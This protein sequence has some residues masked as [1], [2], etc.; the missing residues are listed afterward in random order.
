MSPRI[1][2]FIGTTAELIK[3]MPV[4]RELAARG[5][6]FDVIASG[7]NDLSKSELFEQA[8]L[9]RPVLALNRTLK[10]KTAFGLAI[11]F[12]FTFFRGLARLPRLFRGLDRASTVLIVHGDT[13]STLMG[14]VLGRILGVRVAHIEAGLRSKNFLQPFPEELDRYLTAFFAHIHFCPYASAVCNLERRGG[15]K[16]DT[17]FNTNIDSLAF[18]RSLAPT[19]G[20]EDVPRPP[21]FIFILH[22]QENVLNNALVRDLLDVL[23]ALTARM[24]CLF[25]THELTMTRLRDLGL[26][27]RVAG[28]PN[29]VLTGRRP[30]VEFIRVLDRCEFIMTDG[31]GNQQECYYLGK[32][33]LILRR[34]TESE[35]GLGRNVLVSGNDRATIEQF[36]AGYERYRH[37]EVAPPRRPSEIIVDTLLRPS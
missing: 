13:V 23:T 24:R 18:A 33:C 37:P 8:G 2:F 11:W 7:Q 19:G 9:P 25:V 26:L 3:V 20:H 17:G 1:F 29:I 6:P 35:E 22:R 32:P 21:Y 36:A 14:A 34:L 10:R 31:G 28:N 12:V 15:E 4:M 30:Y 27:E 16:I 5:M